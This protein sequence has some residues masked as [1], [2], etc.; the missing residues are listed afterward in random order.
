MDS[1]I[2]G[3]SIE[4]LAG[5]VTSTD[6]RCPGARFTLGTGWDLGAPQP[7]TNAVGSLLL[8]GERPLG[9]RASNREFKIPVNI[10]GPDRAT[11]AAARE[12]LLATVDQQTY[13][14]TWKRDNGLTIV[15]DAFRAKPSV[16]EYSI[17]K[18]KQLVGL[19]TLDIPAL[20]YG[21]SD[22]LETLSFTTSTPVTLDAYNTVS[23]ANWSKM[24]TGSI[25]GSCAHW[26]NPSL[27]GQTTPAPTYVSTFAPVDI[28]ARGV[29]SHYIGIASP[30]PQIGTTSP[31]SLT[32]AY[33]LTDSGGRKI[34]IG[35]WAHVPP[36]YNTPT[37][38]WELS[39]CPIPQGRIF[40]YT[41]VVSMATTISNAAGK[42]LNNTDVYLDELVA[43]NIATQW[44][45][46]GS[47]VARGVVYLLSGIKGTTHAPLAARATTPTGSGTLN[48]LIVHR[49]GPDAPGTLTPFV[50]IT[51]PATDIVNGSIEYP[52]TSRI[53]G[54]NARFNGTYSVV[55]SNWQWNQPFNVYRTVTVTVR[56]YDYPGA[57][58][59]A[60]KMTT[61]SRL[62]L[63]S[64]TADNVELSDL[65]TLGEVTLPIRDIPPDNT[66]AYFTVSIASTLGA[67]PVNPDRFYDILFLDVQGQTVLIDT[68]NPGY[69]TFY[70]DE[71][72]SDRDMGRVLGS[73]IAGRSRAVSVLENT[74]ASGGPVTVDPGANLLFVY[75]QQGAPSI[76]ATYAPR[77]FNDRLY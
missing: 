50:P 25:S 39:T 44:T 70:L 69:N 46:G 26:T 36:V 17:I 56:Q 76:G 23:G 77:W 45:P 8:D 67:I 11:I 54:L 22:T 20:P 64:P 40:D 74:L 52:V 34:S 30:Q 47:G 31:G 73:P 13:T 2:L 66:D 72:S 6:P 43:T 14:V 53:P 3:S 38:K 9:R 71:P 62:V 12:V 18:E 59:D 51:N 61:V 41:H 1:L 21:R 33:V 55:V 75:S 28:S 15:F 4:L 58:I 60:T 48:N 65:V 27:S 68:V 57:T 19:V 29:L 42:Y 35:D 5:G 7:T 32:L 63:P 24:T 10:F 16:I 49:P 37:P